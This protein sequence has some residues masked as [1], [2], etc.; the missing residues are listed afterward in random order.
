[1]LRDTTKDGQP[2]IPG[3]ESRAKRAAAGRAA[4]RTAGCTREPSA[5]DRRAPNSSSAT[6]RA[7]RGFCP[8][9]IRQAW[10][11]RLLNAYL[12]TTSGRRPFARSGSTP[13]PA[14][15]EEN[16]HADASAQWPSPPRA[17][18]PVQAREVCRKFAAE[19]GL[20]PAFVLEV[21]A[22]LLAA[23]SRKSAS[24]SRPGCTTSTLRRC[25]P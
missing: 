11:E 22:G 4:Q 20:Q 7:V 18:E 14:T 5:G 3:G 2:E 16:A 8:V 24:G 13:R 25:T 9:E 19:L 12:R 1:M 15:T 17:D 6:K 23:R 21:L 10:E